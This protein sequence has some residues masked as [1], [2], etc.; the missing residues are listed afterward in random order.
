[1]MDSPLAHYHHVFPPR[2]RPVL[3]ALSIMEHRVRELH[4]PVHCRNHAVRLRCVRLD[5]LDGAKE[6]G[7]PT[8]EVARLVRVKAQATRQPLDD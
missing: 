5:H 7:V 4:E 3:E 2:F 6:K 8:P 1:M